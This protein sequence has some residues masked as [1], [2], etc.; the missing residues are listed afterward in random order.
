[1]NYTSLLVFLGYLALFIGTLLAVIWWD[2]RK[3]RTRKP[4][5]EDLKL[6]RMPGEYLWR[7]VIE[8]DE[9]DMQWWFIVMLVPMLVAAVMLWGVAHL[10]RTAP[11]VGLVIAV[12]AFAFSVLLSVRWLLMRLQRRA[13]DYLGFFGERYVAE[14]LE[15]LK[16]QGWFIFHDVPCEGATGKF[17]LDHVAIGSGG[18]WVIETKTFRKGRARPGF[19]EHEVVSDG[20]KV[21][22]PWRDD[23]ESLKQAADNARWLRE[24]LAKVT[25]K[26]FDVAAVL[27][28]PGYFVTERKLG[29]VRLA[30]PKALPQVLNS[31]G[32]AVLSSADVDLI[33]RQLES[34]CRN[35]EY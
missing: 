30:N 21:I 22:W 12:V 32:S 2:R 4:F 13:D 20:S 34:R 28:V 5:P 24:W 17:N 3:R 14:W 25:G 7:R 33:R 15:P 6:L 16:A 10:F 18:V 23:T 11:A 27:T 35:V 31:R 29:P 9:S 26:T 1:M 8:N 19:K